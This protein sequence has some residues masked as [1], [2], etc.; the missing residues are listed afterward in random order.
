[1]RLLDLFTKRKPEVKNWTFGGTGWS[2]DY[3]D[4]FLRGWTDD[5]R[6][7]PST[8]SAVMACMGWLLSLIHI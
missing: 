7:D 2:G 1:M 4:S 3:G 5:T 8:N 6:L